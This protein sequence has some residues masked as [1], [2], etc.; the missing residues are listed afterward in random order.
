[1]AQLTISFTSD[2]SAVLYRIKYRRV[3]TSTYT[4]VTTTASPMVITSGIQCGYAYEGTVQAVCVV[5][6]E[7]ASPEVAWNAAA[8]SCQYYWA[9]TVC[10]SGAPVPPSNAVRTTDASIGIGDVVKLTG[11]TYVGYCYT[12]SDTTPITTGVLIDDASGAFANC[13]DCQTS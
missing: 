12:I 4:T 6:P 9:V 7:S 3:G 1:M 5:S 10:T 2:P 8:V 11:S 13:T